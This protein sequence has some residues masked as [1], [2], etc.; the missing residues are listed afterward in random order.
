MDATSLAV[1]SGSG[2]GSYTT[3]VRKLSLLALALVPGAALAQPELTGPDQFPQFR[4]ISGLPGGGFA[5][6]REGLPRFDGAMAL[7][8]PI[9]YGFRPWHG[10][11]AVGVTSTSMSPRFLDTREHAGGSNGT[12]FGLVGV[13]VPAGE[14][15]VGIMVLSIGWDSVWNIQ[16][17]VPGEREGWRLGVG[18][19]DLVGGGGSAGD[20]PSVPGDPLGDRRSSRSLY[21]VATRELQ[22]GIYASLGTGTRRFS[23]VF[24]NVSAQVA[25]RW[26][27]LGEY[28]AF[29]V[30]WGVA[31]D[32]G[33]VQVLGRG[34]HVT[35]FFGYV[36][37]KYASAS[38][39]VSF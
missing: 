37:G 29:N 21:V 1:A 14:L 3:P 11:L 5:L 25:P 32:V 18:V 16:Y 19:Q 35:A 39:A 13:P 2:A 31:H 12:L 38:L 23:G 34:A 17:T 10:V 30:N 28:D 6:S 27:L 4:T 22:P 7:S 9:A 36:R 24:G 8:T 15:T 33:Q 20:L 26:K